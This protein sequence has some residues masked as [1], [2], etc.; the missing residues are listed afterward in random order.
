MHE[1]LCLKSFRI[2]LIISVF[3]CGTQIKQLQAQ[4]QTIEQYIEKFKEAAMQNMQ[5]KRIP[6]SITLAQGILESGAGNSPLAINSN[7]HF[8]I[9][10][11]KEWTGEKYYHDDDAPQ[12][13]FRKYASVSES[14]ADHA[15]FLISRPRYANLFKLSILDYKGWAKELKAAGYATLPTYPE[16]LIGYIEKYKLYQYDSIA[17]F[18]QVSK[19]NV[20]LKS[21]HAAFETRNE[22]DDSKHIS[23]DTEQEIKVTKPI[24]DIK[25]VNGVNYIIAVNG[26]TPKSIALEFELA[27]WQIRRYNDLKDN[28][29]LNSGDQVFIMPKKAKSEEYSEHVIQEGES[30]RDVANKYGVK[31]HSLKQF[32]GISKDDSIEIGTV[33]KLQ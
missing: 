2:G 6:A 10:C 17:E 32:N 11:H 21:N 7:N 3:Y 4:N 5:N 1:I 13:C 14:F 25:T 29:K 16:K 19:G 24:R 28:Q 31:L 12:E 27:E 26:D 30:L 33:V 18:N 9:K 8:G 22:F 20:D 23:K 15:D